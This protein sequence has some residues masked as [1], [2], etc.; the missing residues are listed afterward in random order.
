MVLHKSSSSPTSSSSCHYMLQW[1]NKNRDLF[2]KQ[3]LLYHKFPKYYDLFLNITNMVDLKKKN[4]HTQWS[5]IHQVYDNS[6]ISKQWHSAVS[7]LFWPL[8]TSIASEDA[9]QDL[10]PGDELWPANQEQARQ[11]D[12]PLWVCYPYERCSQCR[13]SAGCWPS[14]KPAC[15]SSLQ[16]AEGAAESTGAAQRKSKHSVHLLGAQQLHETGWERPR[17]QQPQAV[18]PATAQT[19]SLHHLPNQNAEV[20]WTI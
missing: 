12:W 17:L 3:M 16:P 14:H 8:F 2:G 1:P 5:S 9:L 20:W 18:K 6:Q 13:L 19:S 15:H 11:R 7:L 10:C 4:T